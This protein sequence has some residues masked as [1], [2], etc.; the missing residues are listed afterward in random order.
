MAKLYYHENANC[1]VLKAA[2]KDQIAI[3]DNRYIDKTKWAILHD[4]DSQKGES[5][6]LCEFFGQSYPK[7]YTRTEIA[8]DITPWFVRIN[9]NL[10]LYFGEDRPQVCRKTVK[11]KTKEW[12][13]WNMTQYKDRKP[14]S[15]DYLKVNEPEKLFFF[16]NTYDYFELCDVVERNGD[17]IVCK[18]DMT[19][20]M[21]EEIV[22]ARIKKEKEE[23]RQRQEAA[24]ER[25]RRKSL[26]G[27][28]S[29]CGAEGAFLT[30]DPFNCEIYGDYTPVWLCRDCYDSSL[31]DI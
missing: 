30:P 5:K 17:T 25:E 21:Y 16:G 20:E 11:G 10:V 19:N 23:L 18:F 29:C 14:E 13:K 31:G 2:E 22:G 27:Y 28:C 24:A 7:P 12:M 3:N 1:L 15:Y 8:D 26:P 6:R 9:W 4:H